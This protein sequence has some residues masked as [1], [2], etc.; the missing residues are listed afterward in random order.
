MVANA[1]IFGDSAPTIRLRQSAW[2]T[3]RNGV[4]RVRIS[5]ISRFASARRLLRQALDPDH[6]AAQAGDAS[7]PARSEHF[8]AVLK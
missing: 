3:W 1:S 7:R 8:A 5:A 4:S 6:E 2:T